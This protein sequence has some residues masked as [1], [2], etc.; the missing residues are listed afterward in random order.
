MLLRRRVAEWPRGPQRSEDTR[1]GRAARGL[2]LIEANSASA[3]DESEA[4][5]EVPS[6]SA[7]AQA[8]LRQGSAGWPL[9]AIR[10]A[11]H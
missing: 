6:S 7:T 1:G 4:D 5:V 9:H 10:G 8:A 11:G 3:S 2:D